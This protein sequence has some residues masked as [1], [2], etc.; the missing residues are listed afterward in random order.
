LT[1]LI[2]EYLDRIGPRR[3]TIILLTLLIWICIALGVILYAMGMGIYRTVMITREA[4]AGDLP[5][6]LLA[7]AIW[8]LV[9]LSIPLAWAA[10]RVWQAHRAER[11]GSEAALDR[12]EK[13]LFPTEHR[14]DYTENARER[15]AL[16]SLEAMELE[17]LGEHQS[18]DLTVEERVIALA[19]NVAS[20]QRQD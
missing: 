16:R 4:F 18:T 3:S 14:V 7:A 13:H 20:R 19:T 5:D 15:L 2:E 12:V 9:L 8:I 11:W 1:H 10:R 17:L 6:I